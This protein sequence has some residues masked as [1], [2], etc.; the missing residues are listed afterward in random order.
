[1]RRSL[2][3]ILLLIA[4]CALLPAQFSSNVQGVVRDPSES[5]VPGATATLKNVS[6]GVETSA[7]T[8]NAGYYRFSSLA[9]GQYELTVR[10]AGFQATTVAVT[11]LT[12]S[13]ATIDVALKVSAAAE[14]V[15]ITAEVPILNLSET[16][17]QTTLQRDMIMELPLKS[18]DGLSL[19]TVAPGVTGLGSSGS[20]GFGAADNFA[21]ER[22]LDFNAGG[23]NLSGNQ[24]TVDG[25]NVTSNIMQGTTNLSPNPDSIEEVSVQTNTFSVEQGRASA[26]QI[27]MT[28]KS[29]TNDFHGTGTYTFNNQ[30]LTARTVFTRRYEPFKRNYVNGTFGGPVIRNKS[31][32]F[33]SVELLRSQY[34]EGT[35][36]RTFE[37]PQF[38]DWAKQ[39]FPN[40]LGTKI[41][42]DY[43]MANTQI[44]SVARTARDLLPTTCGT[45]ATSNLPCS[46]PMVM[47]G[48]FFRSPSRN[49][50]QYSFRGDQYLNN[51]K[52]RLYAN[53]Y[54]KILDIEPLIFRKGIDKYIDND[55]VPAF[56]ANWSH[57]VSPVII[58]EFGF[59]YLKMDGRRRQTNQ[60]AMMLP[61]I[62]I[63]NQSSGIS[64]GGPQEWIQHN[65]NWRDVLSWVRSTHTL[66]F[67]FD[68]WYGD[69]HA[70]FH[71]GSAKPSFV[72]NNLLD[73]VMDQPYSQSN[74]AF[75]P[76]TG[77][78]AKYD[79]WY[80]MKTFG[81][82][83][84]DEWKVRPNLTLT[85]GLRWDDFGNPY[86]VEGTRLGNI[87]LAPGSNFDER[88]KTAR[89]VQM[90][91]MYN[92]HRWRNFTPRLGY[93][94]DPGRGGKW[95][96]RGGLGMYKDWLPLGE[97]NR[98]RANP[99]SF[100]FPTLLATQDPKPVFSMGTTTEYPFGFKLPQLPGRQLDQYGGL[101]GLQ[102]S[103]GGIDPDLVAPSTLQW[104]VG[105]ERH[106][107]GNLIAGMNYSGSRSWDMVNGTD[108]NRFAGDFLDGK[109]DRLHPS[110]GQM[111]YEWNRNSIH[112]N[113]IILT[114]RGSAGRYGS[115]Q[116][117]YTM[118]RTTD[119]GQAGSRIN[120]DGSF[121][122]PDQHQLDLYKG[123]ADWDIRQRF[124]LSGL[125][126]L[127]TPRQNPVL[128][129][130]AGNWAMSSVIVLQSGRPFWVVNTAAFNP[131]RDA[132]GRVIGFQPGSGDYNADG[133]N[134]D[135][136]NTPSKD[137]TGSFSRQQYIRGLFTAADF[138]APAPGTQGDLKRNIYRNP[139]FANVDVAMVKKI[140]IGLL[141]ERGKLELRFEFF[142]VL[143]RVNLTGIN[144]NPASPQFG[145][146]TST[147]DPR[148]IQLCGRIQF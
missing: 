8:N 85:L 41:L 61:N 2:K 93:A 97:E 73:L 16:R 127:P 11:L 65:Y 86:P 121:G 100:L 27:S 5:V 117:S 51:N 54:N 62:S 134:Y 124:S 111:F 34:S 43:P 102:T 69:D 109:L 79:Y 49:G 130:I 118:A 80:K 136:P 68:A 46:M 24:Y 71:G 47:N 88:I 40:S 14:Q 35:T 141:G 20:A 33:S 50:L 1:M 113:G 17:V 112:Y 133:F 38:V 9:P 125:V 19:A 83:V 10:A 13:T 101:V 81:G 56:Q 119:Y 146:S 92:S 57:T 126:N 103:V 6:T 94:W 15:T 139:G 55:L 143:N 45:A 58:N 53:F 91:G 106:V 63:N 70:L 82:F 144:N 84:Q 28:T 23:R 78:V 48:T 22:M 129:S 132:S 98:V 147:L 131:I 138:P 122:Y 77:Q 37:A 142:N 128:T 25:L 59:G 105:V 108:L 120:R 137:F 7:T 67:G 32:F 148:I 96:I 145:R 21:N 89:I 87:K 99:P 18:R 76:L 110:F 107:V 60:T 31:F 74:I 12:A 115:F 39:Q 114:L 44:T 140:P 116:A 3:S 72:F 104:V 36:V 42:S 123:D 29:G 52:D 26:L 4:T 90:P 66:K 30:D 135:I 64:L 75:D 95:V